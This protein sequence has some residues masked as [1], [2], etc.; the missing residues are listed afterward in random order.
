MNWD[1]LRMAAAVARHGGFAGAAAE[2]G[3]DSTTV[4]RRVA[5]LE[6]GLGLSLFEASD[7]VRRP[8]RA[9]EDAF[10]RLR[11]LEAE[12]AAFRAAA[13]ANAGL[14]GRV[15]VAATASIAEHVLAPSVSDFLS[16]HPGLR[17]ELETADA[18]VDLA[19]WEADLAIRLARPESGGFL[20]R[21]IA[22]LRLYLCRPRTDDAPSALICAYPESLVG[23]P[24]MAAL[25][26]ETDG[27]EARLSTNNPDVIRR[28]VDSGGA[29]GVLLEHAVARLPQDGSV[30]A[31]LLPER[32]EVWLLIQEARRGDAA[33][34]AAADWIAGCFAERPGA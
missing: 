21:R 3:V 32:R 26:R 17:L 20:A 1:D 14:A 13:T 6:R 5:R 7:G 30:E 9:A 8:T 28:A 4:S 23:T 31:V 18:N 16:R 34:R 24:E 25:R 19:R 27:A 12:A 29:V 15:R 33:V 11:V 22:S 2:L 10:A